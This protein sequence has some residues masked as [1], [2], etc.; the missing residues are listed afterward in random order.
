MS[1][2]NE[3][4]ASI[5]TNK[6][7]VTMYGEFGG[8]QNTTEETFLLYKYLHTLDTNLISGF[9]NGWCFLSVFYCFYFTPMGSGYGVLVSTANLVQIVMEKLGKYMLCV[10]SI[11]RANSIVGFQAILIFTIF[12]YT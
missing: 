7:T 6:P 4:V 1:R 5:Q 9:L 2:S 11:I 8:K 10:L 3:H 12:F